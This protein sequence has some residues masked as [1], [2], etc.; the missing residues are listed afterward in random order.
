M[1]HYPI[2]EIWRFDYVKG[3]RKVQTSQCTYYSKFA[4]K[5]QLDEVFGAYFAA[6]WHDEWCGASYAEEKNMVGLLTDN[7]EFAHKYSMEQIER[8]AP[9]H[10]GASFDECTEFR[11]RK[12]DYYTQKE[13]LRIVSREEFKQLYRQLYTELIP[14]SNP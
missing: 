4:L 8:G 11:I 10:T 2:A 14:P 6:K 7:V 1:F 13:E 5:S 12:I 9:Y 3:F